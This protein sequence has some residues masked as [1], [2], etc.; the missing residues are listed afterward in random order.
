[1]VEDVGDKDGIGKGDH[2]DEGDTVEG[3]GAGVLLTMTFQ[4]PATV[5]SP[6]PNLPGLA[7]DSP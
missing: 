6:T 3:D 4:S 7:I 5:F 2:D 1:M